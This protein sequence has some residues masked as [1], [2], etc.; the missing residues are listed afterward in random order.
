MSSSMIHLTTAPTLLPTAPTVFVYTAEKFIHVSYRQEFLKLLTIAIRHGV[1]RDFGH[2]S[3]LGVG[4][5][6]G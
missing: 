3:T 1:H 6:G 2:S 4:H 5:A